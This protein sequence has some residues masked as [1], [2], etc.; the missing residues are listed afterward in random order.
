MK[1][2]L[3]PF[4]F[5]FSLVLTLMGVL[6][7]VSGCGA[8]G[9]SGAQSAAAPNVT[10]KQMSKSPM[11]APQAPAQGET[12]HGHK[13]GT[14]G[15]II[16]SI[17]ADNYH[18]EA[19]IEK[20]GGLKLLM[21]D[22]DESKLL[23]VDAQTLT[24]YAKT[25]TD[26]ESVAVELTSSPQNGDAVGKT[27]QFQGKLPPE[28]IGKP[29]DVTIPSIRIKGDRFRIGF[30]T[31]NTAHA[32]DLPPRVEDGMERM[33]YLTP[34]GKYTADD[35]KAN[36]NV[37][38][39][40]KFKGLHAKHDLLPKAG[41]K[42]CPITLTKSSPQFSWIIGGK[43]YDFCCPPCVDEFVKQAKEAPDQIK[44]PGEY[45]KKETIASQK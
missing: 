35:I 26:A 22:R 19:L 32:D 27:S 12:E 6:A 43:T 21:L 31:A 24:A 1:N 30:S 34:G 10:S 23:E 42:I 13:P 25:G 37:T 36:G 17:G 3:L 40:Q 9:N 7:S 8:S 4:A 20:G 18:A 11:T 41:D 44:E 38:A 14:H 45:V 5:Q 15:G 16:V 2:K 28:L 33:L 29:L 39:T